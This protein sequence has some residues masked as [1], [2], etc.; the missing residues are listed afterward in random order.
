MA[1]GWPMFE[2]SDMGDAV[3]RE[4]A[5]THDHLDLF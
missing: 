5:E 2:A 4:L 1:E 3:V